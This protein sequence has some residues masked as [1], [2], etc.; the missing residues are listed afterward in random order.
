M[1]SDRFRLHYKLT[2]EDYKAYFSQSAQRTKGKGFVARFLRPLIGG[3]LTGLIVLALKQAGFIASR[4]VEMLFAGAVFAILLIGVLSILIKNKM[5]ANMV[6]SH[7][8]MTGKFTLAAYDGG[9]IQITGKQSTANYDWA[10]FLDL[11]DKAGMVILWVDAGAGVLLPHSAYENE[12]ERL[13]FV[14]FVNER[15]EAHRQTG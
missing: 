8:T 14:A 13:E 3:L 12:E 15:I 1:V 5:I 2:P 6:G 11:T 10:A 9:G 7:D 4:D